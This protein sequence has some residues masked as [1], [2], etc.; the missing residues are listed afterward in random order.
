MAARSSSSARSMSAGTAAAE[1]D[2]SKA[3]DPR[4][5]ASEAWMLSLRP[6][7]KRSSQPASAPGSVGSG[8][9]PV[10][11]RSSGA[12]GTGAAFA[13]CD[14]AGGGTARPVPAVATATEAP[15]TTLLSAA[16]C[17]DAALGDSAPGTLPPER[18][19]SRTFAEA[20]DCTPLALAPWA[21]AMSMTRMNSCISGAG[22]MGLAG[23]IIARRCG[24]CPGTERRTRGRR[25]VREGV[26]ALRAREIDARFS[27]VV[28]GARA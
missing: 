14:G 5:T 16:G 21:I 25:G 7:E 20:R 11:P 1:P 27:V 6:K 22:R 10:G 13:S 3:H 2:E 17:T 15:P 12:A 9:M 18:P 8:A 28:E 24:S 19:D 4:A 23:G 26:E